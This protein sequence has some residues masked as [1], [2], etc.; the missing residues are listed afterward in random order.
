MKLNIH[1]YKGPFNSLLGPWVTVGYITP[2]IKNIDECDKIVP[3]NPYLFKYRSNVNKF[4]SLLANQSITVKTS[5][6]EIINDIGELCLYYNSKQIIAGAKSL[7][8]E[9]EILDVNYIKKANNW[10]E[11]LCVIYSVF[12]RHQ[13]LKR[14]SNKNTNYLN[15]DYDIDRHIDVLKRYKYLPSY[16]IVDKCLRLFEDVKP[17]PNWYLKEIDFIKNNI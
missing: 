14:Y 10:D 15:L 1:S 16:Y 11:R 6:S 13:Y 17:K 12:I 8:E 2:T 4:N 5:S 7:L 3:K 9:D